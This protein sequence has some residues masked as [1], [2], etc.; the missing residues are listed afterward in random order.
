LRIHDSGLAYDE[1]RDAMRLPTYATSATP[2]PQVTPRS[3]PGPKGSQNG[4]NEGGRDTRCQIWQVGRQSSARLLDDDQ[5]PTHFNRSC[6]TILF[7]VPGAKTMQF[8]FVP[9][10]ALQP[11]RW[12]DARP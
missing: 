8:A 9:D 2:A 11:P 5:I 10:R 4:K 3:G 1:L 7:S 12:A 6:L